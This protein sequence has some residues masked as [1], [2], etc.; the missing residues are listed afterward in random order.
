MQ[1]L[2]VMKRCFLVVVS[3]LFGFVDSDG[4][5]IVFGFSSLS[6]RQEKLNVED[7]AFQKAQTLMIDMGCPSVTQPCLLTL[8]PCTFVKPRSRRRQ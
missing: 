6:S 1:S 7:H 5:G 4:T 8:Q 3:F 2:W